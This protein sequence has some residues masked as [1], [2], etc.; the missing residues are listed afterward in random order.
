MS[1]IKQILDNHNIS[2]ESR[3]ELLFDCVYPFI[4]YKEYHQ[5][6]KNINITNSRII[7]YP[8]PLYNISIFINNPISNN[9][10]SIFKISSTYYKFT[11]HYYD[12][13]CHTITSYFEVINGDSIIFKISFIQD[14][15]SFYIVSI[16]ETEKVSI[17]DSFEY[18]VDFYD[19]EDLRDFIIHKEKVFNLSFDSYLS[20]IKS[21]IRIIHQKN[22]Y[23][24][25]KY[26]P[27]FYKNDI[28]IEKYID[29]IQKLY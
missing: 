4:T 18:L 11:I 21:I 2:D 13:Y 20:K 24:K 8:Y 19:F 14:E 23:H 6:K 10:I 7:K 3:K 22:N 27:N 25:I 28:D 16:N 26:L 12:L 1:I 17:Q 9:D 29:V 15:N 5:N